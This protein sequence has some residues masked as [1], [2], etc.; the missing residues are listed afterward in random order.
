MS[1]HN[2]GVEHEPQHAASS[3]G[4]REQQ[5]QRANRLHEGEHRAED[6]QSTR[7]ARREANE[8]MRGTGAG[9]N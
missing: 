3:Q 1:R 6:S 2:R 7:D 5:D 9:V 8:T 4:H